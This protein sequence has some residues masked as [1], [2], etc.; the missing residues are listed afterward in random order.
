M[1][2]DITLINLENL[3]VNNLKLPDERFNCYVICNHTMP[4]KELLLKLIQGEAKDINVCGKYAGIWEKAGD[5]ICVEYENNGEKPSDWFVT[6]EESNIDSFIN[7][8]AFAHC[9]YYDDEVLSHD[10]I[11]LF[12]DDENLKNFVLKRV[13]W[14][15]EDT[16]TPDSHENDED[17]D[18]SKDFAL[19]KE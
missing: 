7:F 13:E 6:T 12:Y 19:K 14:M 2:S 11:L 8:L 10:P 17:Y 3:N 5:D 18:Y 16:S 9:E 4:D 1:K 15:L